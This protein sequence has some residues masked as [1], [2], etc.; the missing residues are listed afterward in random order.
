MKIMKKSD[1]IR[2][3]DEQASEYD[4]QVC[5]YKWFG[6]DLTFGMSFEYVNPHDRLLDIGIGTGLSSLP[7]AKVG[8]EIFGIDG[9]MKMLNVCKSKD[10]AKELKHFDLRNT[11]LPYSNGFFD[12]VISCGVLHFFGDLEA[13]FKEVDRVIKPGGIFTFTVLAQVFEKGENVEGYSETSVYGGVVFMHGDRYIEE[14]IQG[15]GFEKLKELKF[16]ARS[17]QKDSDDLLCR[18]YVALKTGG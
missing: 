9:S 16:L 4:Q 14:V 8:L 5:E 12:H 13:L 1:S 10:F 6:H 18:A 3:H 11:P 15:G 2:T 17:G 7:F